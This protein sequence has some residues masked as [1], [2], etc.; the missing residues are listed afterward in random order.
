[1]SDTIVIIIISSLRVTCS[2]QSPQWLVLS[3]IECFFSKRLCSILSLN[4]YK[5]PDE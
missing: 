2:Q 3:H 1:M 4:D 5:M